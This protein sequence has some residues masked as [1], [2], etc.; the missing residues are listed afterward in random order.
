MNTPLEHTS[1]NR[2]VSRSDKKIATKKHRF[3]FIWFFLA[4]TILISGGIVG[5]YYYIEQIKTEITTDVYTQ[6]E[7]QLNRIQLNYE[8]QLTHLEQTV[9]TNISELQARIDSLT[10]LL[11]FT[12]D[13]ATDQ[14]DNS[15]Q[16]YAQLA[17]VQ[18]QLQELK[19]NLEVLQ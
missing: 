17:E 1:M 8:Q 14:T 4:W 5:A 19:A 13:N 12:R 7:Q 15:A 2:A 18:R 16:L 11:I 10:Q 3:G 9:H 6:T